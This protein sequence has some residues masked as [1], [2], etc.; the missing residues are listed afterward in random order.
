MKK[1]YKPRRNKQRQSQKRTKCKE[2][3]F[4]RKNKE[5]NQSVKKYIY[6]LEYIII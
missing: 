4:I 5:N 6:I 2:R 3:K 1:K